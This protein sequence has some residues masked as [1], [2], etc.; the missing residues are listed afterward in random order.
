MLFWPAQSVVRET[1]TTT[2]RKPAA[3]LRGPAVRVDR[4]AAVLQAHEDCAAAQ[5]VVTAARPWSP[6]THALF[7]AAAREKAAALLFSCSHVVR[8][9]CRCTAESG[10]A[11]HVTVALVSLLVV[12]NP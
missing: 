6:E 11:K 5:L 8:R 4:A 3:I 2:R 1:R 7:P 12:R 9:R 10:L